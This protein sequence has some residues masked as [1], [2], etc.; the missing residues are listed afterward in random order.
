ME[1]CYNCGC[2]L[3]KDK[4][5]R[6][7]IPMKAL[8]I[9]YPLD[10]L[11]ESKTVPGC[12]VCNNYYSKIEEDFKN[13]IAL[14]AVNENI[15]ISDEFI[16]SAGRSPK[17]RSKVQLLHNKI[18]AKFNSK[19][20]D[21]VHIKNFKGLFWKRYGLPLGDDYRINVYA[22]ISESINYPN[23]ST[24]L[25]DLLRKR[26]DYEHSD[27]VVHRDVFQYEIKD[28]GIAFQCK[29][30]YFKKLFAHVYAIKTIV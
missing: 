26:F 16:L 14:W 5:T 4:K 10:K 8:Y 12:N 22:D 25:K 18:I 15:K 20:Y 1:H 27:F 11:P 17:L 13:I 19:E 3:T 23:I 9:G 2:E 6:E 29:M 21:D 24:E 7:H 30:L 28:I